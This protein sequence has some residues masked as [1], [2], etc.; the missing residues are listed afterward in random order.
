MRAF[1][2]T[3]SNLFEMPYLDAGTFDWGLEDPKRN[4]RRATLIQNT[5]H[6]V[7][8]SDQFG[9]LYR[10]TRSQGGDFA[11]VVADT[12]LI[13][14]FM[15]YVAAQ[16]GIFGKSATQIKVWA[17]IAPGMVGIT[18]D[19]FFNIILAEYDTMV[20]DRVHTDD[21]RKFWLRRMAEALQK[22][23]HIGLL[24]HSKIIA[25]DPKIGW[26]QWLTNVDGWGTK[27]EHHDRLF[28]ITKQTMVATAPESTETS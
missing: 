18:G 2:I 15:E 27:P 6:K 23:M 28:Y 11:Y 5:P 24:D 22:G 9:I 16:R 21:G 13:T 12:K 8:R 19:V 25:Y 7:V 17:S 14:Y 4:L 26:N 1:E 10:R 3:K 20:S